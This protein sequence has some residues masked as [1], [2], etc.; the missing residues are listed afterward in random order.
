M[1]QVSIWKVQMHSVIASYRCI[2]KGE[3]SKWSDTHR[4]TI[5][6]FSQV[7]PDM[8]QQSGGKMGLSDGKA[9]IRV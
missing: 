7:I 9:P 1:T 4:D 2:K 5:L 3:L 8:M 6:S